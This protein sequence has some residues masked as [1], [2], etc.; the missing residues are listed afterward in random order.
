MVET[1]NGNVILNQLHK[2]GISSVP[3]P[4]ISSGS[5]LTIGGP[6]AIYNDYYALIVN[7]TL[8]NGRWEPCERIGEKTETNVVSVAGEITFSD[9]MV[10]NTT[11]WFEPDCV[12]TIGTG[13][14]SGMKLFLVELF[15]ENN[16]TVGSPPAGGNLVTSGY[17]TC[18]QKELSIR[19]G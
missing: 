5:S 8:R 16:L 19:L 13:A 17:E 4:Y 7:I 2:T 9:G 14:T 18:M 11:I 10:H 3:M 6:G 1:W 15:R 12:W